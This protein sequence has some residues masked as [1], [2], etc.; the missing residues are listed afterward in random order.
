LVAQLVDRL[1]VMYAARVVEE[2]PADAVFHSPRHPY[3]RG[4]IQSVPNIDMDQ[5]E[6]ATMEGRPPDLVNPPEGCRF[7]PRC[8]Y[9][10]DKCRVTSPP[11]VT[12]AGEHRAACWLN[13][14]GNVPWL[15]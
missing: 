6:L 15:N 2:G 12:A 11:M 4:L 8:P 5:I 13:E 1:A 14:E 7:A 10:M 3:T 9:A